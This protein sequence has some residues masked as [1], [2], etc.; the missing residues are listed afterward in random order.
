MFERGK[1]GTMVKEPIW[2]QTMSTYK[3]TQAPQAWTS[4]PSYN[5]TLP[6]LNGCGMRSQEGGVLN[7]DKAG[8]GHKLGAG[9]WEPGSSRIGDSPTRSWRQWPRQAGVV[10][11][12]P[13]FVLTECTTPPT[14]SHLPQTWAVAA[15]VWLQGSFRLKRLFLG[16][17]RFLRSQETW[18]SPN[19]SGEAGVEVALCTLGIVVFRNF[20]LG[21][22]QVTYFLCTLH[23]PAYF[24]KARPAT[25]HAR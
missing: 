4:K 15:Q 5:K 18:L 14:V 1:E 21:W 20:T 25:T 19:F 6:D 2:L 9:E 22:E 17:S 12:L 7:F 10:E 24:A 11:S 8:R 3:N 16:H 13:G 23:L